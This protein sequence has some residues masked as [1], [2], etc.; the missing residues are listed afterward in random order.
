MSKWIYTYVRL[1]YVWLWLGT[2]MEYLSIG[3]G[4]VSVEQNGKLL[5]GNSL[6]VV[7]LVCF[8]P[9]PE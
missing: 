2:S 7:V 8:S 5:T 1:I 9:L 3:G 6:K 4:D